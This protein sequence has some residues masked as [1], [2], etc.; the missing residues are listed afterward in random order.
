MGEPHQV[1][2]VRRCINDDEVMTILNCGNGSLEVSEFDG[3]VFATRAL[4]ARAMQKWV[5]NSRSARLLRAQPRR[6]SM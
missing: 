6:L 5:G 1:A 2:V 4:S 3:L